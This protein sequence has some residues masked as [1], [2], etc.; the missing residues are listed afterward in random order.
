MV[1]EEQKRRFGVHKKYGI[2]TSTKKKPTRGIL[3]EVIGSQETVLF[4]DKPFGF[5]N[6]MKQDLVKN[7]GRD[8]KTLRIR[9]YFNK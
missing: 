3:V 2:T 9:Y 6:W 8:P 5:L 7:K 4:E 1:S